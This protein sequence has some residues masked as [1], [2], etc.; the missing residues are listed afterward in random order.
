MRGA[1]RIGLVL[2]LVIGTGAMAQDQD[3]DAGT[4]SGT[5]SGAES[6]TSAERVEAAKDAAGVP[7]DL[8]LPSGQKVRWLETL[9]DIGGP[10]GLTYRFRFLAPAIAKKGGTVSAEAVQDDM[11]ALCDGFALPRLPNQGPRPEELVISLSDKPVAFGAATPG[12]TQYFEAY[13][14][15]GATCAWEGF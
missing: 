11:Q 9:R 13:R 1:T 12:V 5:D 15:D 3:A 6:G 10:A 4:D 8:A 7:V 14:P 2:A